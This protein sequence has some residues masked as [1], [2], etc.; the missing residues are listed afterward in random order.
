M[1]NFHFIIVKILLSGFLLISSVALGQ[2]GIGTTDPDASSMLDIQS[3]AKGVLIPRMTTLQRTAIATPATG[4]LV[5]DT[6]TQSFWFYSSSWTE[7]KDGTPDKIIN[8]EGDTRVEVEQS[9]DEDV[10][11]LTT[12]G[13]ERMTIDATGNTRIGDIAG[14]NDTKIEA[15]GTLMF[16]G[17]AEVWDDLRVSLD[18]GSSSA[19]L[20]YFSGSSG[21]QIW[22][23]RNNEGLE[24]MSFQVQLPHSYK[25]GTTIYPHLHWTPRA[26]ESGDIEWNFDY[27]WVNYDA[28]TPLVFSAKTTNTVVATGGFTANTHM[29]TALSSGNVGLDGTG[30]KI[31]SI[32]ICRLWRNSGDTQDTYVDDAG[33]L[34]LDFHYQI[35]MVGS[36]STFAK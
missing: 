24:A 1:K 15:D 8:A 21:G 31:S 23:F 22:Y 26:T 20:E 2:V 12:S 10:I 27:T 16:E 13:S 9:A 29:I 4:L 19:S 6:D 28:T 17:G 14:G 25:E 36:R 32:L 11:H 3:D 30:K 33:L 18:K 34:S 7:L 5:F 35:D